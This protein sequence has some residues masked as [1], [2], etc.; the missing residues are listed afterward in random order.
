VRE[1]F[2][3][4][5][6]SNL[7]P[8][9]TLP[10]SE[11]SPTPRGSDAVTNPKI[12]TGAIDGRTLAVDSVNSSHIQDRQVSDDDL[13]HPGLLRRDQPGRHDQ[14]LRGGQ[15]RAD[16]QIRHRPRQ[17]LDRDV[18]DCAFSAS[19]AQGAVVFGTVVVGKAVNGPFSLIVQC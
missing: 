2:E 5:P 12:E 1:P 8:K 3:L 17:L 7:P 10:P 14:A 18:H 19:A 6:R 4:P 15:H 11:L 13:A 16:P 9:Q